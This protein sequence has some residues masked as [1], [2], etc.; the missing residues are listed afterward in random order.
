MISR[1]EPVSPSPP[2]AHGSWSL[3]AGSRCSIFGLVLSSSILPVLI[4]VSD[5]FMN[6][7]ISRN[8]DRYLLS[9]AV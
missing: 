4:V 3:L 9:R 8:I 7:N 6:K 5:K 2:T 1:F